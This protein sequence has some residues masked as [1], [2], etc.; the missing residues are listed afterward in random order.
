MAGDV[1]IEIPDG[2]TLTEDGKRIEI[3]VEAEDFLH[4]VDLI[5]DIALLAEEHDHH[6]DVHLTSYKQLTVASWSHDV[7]GLSKRDEALAQ[8]INEVLADAGVR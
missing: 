3:R 2:W 5:Q 6:P 8:A 1:P 4:A 7:G